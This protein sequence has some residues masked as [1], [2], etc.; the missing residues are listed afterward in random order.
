MIKV[1]QKEKE[2]EDYWVYQD[3]LIFKPAFNKKIYNNE[4]LSNYNRII[5]SNYT[6][7]SICIKRNNKFRN[8]CPQFQFS[9]FNQ[10]LELPNTIRYLN[11]G[12]IFN[13]SINLPNSIR[14]LRLGRRFNQPISNLPNSLEELTISKNNIETINNLEPKCKVIY[15]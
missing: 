14:Y 8:N 10:Q 4:L 7:P 2:T 15:E 5:F 9:K 13:T 6:E 1:K 12:S 11:F 3:Y